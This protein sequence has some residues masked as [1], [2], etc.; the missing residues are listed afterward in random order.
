MEVSIP[1]LARYGVRSR[2]TVHYLAAK[3]LQALWQSWE[4]EA[5]L[6]LVSTWD[7]CWVPRFKRQTG[8]E[9]ER[10]EK[11]KHLGAASLSNHAW[12]TAF[13]INASLHPLGKKLPTADPFGALFVPARFEGWFPGADFVQR[14]DPMHFELAG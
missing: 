14:P 8:T 3:P 12:A 7:G 10:A 9:A 11:C 6:H 2:V 5:L 13:D 4:D 1:Q